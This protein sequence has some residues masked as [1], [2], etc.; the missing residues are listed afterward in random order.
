VPPVITREEYLDS[1]IVTTASPMYGGTAMPSVNVFGTGQGS[2]QAHRQHKQRS[3]ASGLNG[4]LGEATS[5]EIPE[6]PS[7]ASSIS[8][9]SVGAAATGAGDDDSAQPDAFQLLGSLMRKRPTGTQ[10]RREQAQAAEE[11]ARRA[12]A[13]AQQSATVHP[14]VRSP[15][16]EVQPKLPEPPED[17]L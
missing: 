15:E 2:A 4:M 8:E 11:T 17:L 9:M 12:E 3:A 13:E 10:A 16:E 14:V 7:D 5:S 1:G 6:G